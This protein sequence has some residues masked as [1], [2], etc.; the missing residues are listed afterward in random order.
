MVRIGGVVVDGSLAG[1]LQGL[2][3]RYVADLEQG[4]I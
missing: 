1:Q 3:E 4:K 2:N